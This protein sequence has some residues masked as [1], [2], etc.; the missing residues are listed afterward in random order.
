[1]KQVRE[2]ERA[3]FLDLVYGGR[4]EFMASIDAGV[5]YVVKRFYPRGL[6]LEM[7]A[8]MGRWRRE[9]P[10]SWHP[11]YDGVPD[12]H[13]INDLYP[14][15]YVKARMRSFYFHRFNERRALFDRFK[16]IFEMKNFL[17]GAPRDAYYDTV[18]SQRVIS[19]LTCAC[20]GTKAMS[21]ERTGATPSSGSGM[22]ADCGVVGR[23]IIARSVVMPGAA[24]S[25]L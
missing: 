7:R 21:V 9:A 20:S 12:Y 14:H 8:L 2:I 10:P 25:G 23:P 1:M 19:R 13:R 16:E 22:G 6:L 17:A 24:S 11:C 3:R 5:C 18:P 15:S 4:D